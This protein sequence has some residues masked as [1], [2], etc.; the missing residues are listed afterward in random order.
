M[1][2]PACWPPFR[3]RALALAFNNGMEFAGQ[4]KMVR[5]LGVEI[6]FAQSCRACDRD[7]NEH[8]GAAES[9]PEVAAGRLRRA[10]ELI[11]RRPL[12]ELRFRTLCEVFP[13]ACRGASIPSPARAP[14]VCTV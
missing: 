14:Q 10:V 5:S 6:Y 3:A 13:G 8:T 12:K 2:S 4:G 1:P 7:L 9:M 11:S